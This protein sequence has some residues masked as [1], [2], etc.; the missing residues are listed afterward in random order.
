M[1]GSEGN[2]FVVDTSGVMSRRINLLTR[3]LV[4][5]S[6]VLNEIRK[7]KLG[8]YIDT[9]STEILV[10]NAKESSRKHVID[11]AA[12]TGDIAVLSETDIAVLATAY[13]LR[14]GIITDDY[15][16]QNV[17]HF[18]KIPYEGSDLKPI[19]SMVRWAFKCTGCGKIYQSTRENCEIC[20]HGLRRISVRKA[21]KK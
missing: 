4:F 1:D 14:A 10:Y 13:E 18:L 11:E 16:I 5:P 6:A 21:G 19:G 7:G 2:R 3:N 17:A 15:A 20:G 8:S 12:K 9:I